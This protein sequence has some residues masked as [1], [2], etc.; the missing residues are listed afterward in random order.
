[1]CLQPVPY[2][3]K[4][5]YVNIW[6]YMH[7]S[8]ALACIFKVTLVDVGQCLINIPYVRLIAYIMSDECVVHGYTLGIQIGMD[9][10]DS[11]N[12]Q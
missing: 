11:G 4:H 10:V 6:G 8:I 1:M 5:L 12:T 9:A 2:M 3:F 7:V